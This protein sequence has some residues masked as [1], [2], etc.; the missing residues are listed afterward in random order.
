LFGEKSHPSDILE[1]A[2]S[3][4]P[5]RAPERVPSRAPERIFRK[6]ITLQNGRIFVYLRDFSPG[7]LRSRYGDDK[8]A[9]TKDGKI[10]PATFFLENLGWNA[11]FVNGTLIIDVRWLFNINYVLR[12]DRA[13]NLLAFLYT[14]SGI[15]ESNDEEK[16]AAV[17]VLQYAAA[18][19]NPY[20]KLNLGRCWELG[21]GL[22]RDCQE[23]VQFYRQVAEEADR[24]GR[25][26]DR[27]SVPFCEVYASAQ[28]HYGRCLF[29]GIGVPMNAEQAVKYF[30]L[31]ADQG[32]ALGQYGYGLCFESGTGIAK[33]EGEAVKYFRLSAAQG[34]AYAQFCLEEL[35]DWISARQPVTY[36]KLSVAQGHAGATS[37][38]AKH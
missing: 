20:A 30:K 4:A 15:L 13:L 35:E 6:G 19:G 22:R 3:R 11:S 14:I 7:L 32:H 21:V 34:C 2:S 10:V 25:I 31:S 33:D 23:A 12:D 36:R 37:P 26:A 24:H 8:P 1:H 5:E 17:N 18:Q 27:A 9:N 28:Y 38:I 16:L 29:Y